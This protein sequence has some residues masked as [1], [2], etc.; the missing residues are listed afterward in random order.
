MLFTDGLVE[1]RNAAGELY[2]MDRAIASFKAGSSRDSASKIM[3]FVTESFRE[4]IDWKG[5]F[6]EDDIS[7]VIVRKARAGEV[8]GADLTLGGART[9]NWTW[10]KG[11]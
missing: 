7:I 11:E 5:Y 10:E 4:F 1:A 3:N 2:G 8:V 9:T 6:Q